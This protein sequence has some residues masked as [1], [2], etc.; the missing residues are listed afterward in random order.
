MWYKMQHSLKLFFV[1]YLVDWT[2]YPIFLDY[3]EIL[4]F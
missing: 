4:K 2:V 3:K 1:I